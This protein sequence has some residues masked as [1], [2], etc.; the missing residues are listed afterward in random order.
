MALVVRRDQRLEPIQG[1]ALMEVHEG[2]LVRVQFRRKTRPTKAVVFMLM[3][4]GGIV[5]LVVGI[6]SR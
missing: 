3:A 6:L 5:A 1:R 4:I 2:N